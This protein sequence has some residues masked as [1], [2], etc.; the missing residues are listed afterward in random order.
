MRLLNIVFIIL[1]LNPVKLFAEGTKMDN[2]QFPGPADIQIPEESLKSQPAPPAPDVN[3]KN[4]N[5]KPNAQAVP[6]QNVNTLDNSDMQLKPQENPTENPQE[7]RK[8]KNKD[9]SKGQKQDVKTKD[10]RENVKTDAPPINED[11][12]EKKTADGTAESQKNENSKN[13][14]YSKPVMSEDGYIY[15][16]VGRRDPFRPFHDAKVGVGSLLGYGTRQL[17]PLERFDAHSL[18]VVAI[19]WGTKKPKA[20]VEDPDHK[21]HTVFKGMRV[22][23][24]DG[25]IAE[26]REGE[27]VIAE[28]FDYNG[29]LTKESF[30]L[31]IRK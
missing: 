26:I 24:N 17:E 30:I 3:A 20:L 28:V 13:V 21:I 27:I 9:M 4:N 11:S 18:Q 25:V 22:G 1:L 10:A 14:N 12:G 16:P 2:S 7:N 23:K 19:I 29:K 5:V 6:P 31:P 15:D 8:Q